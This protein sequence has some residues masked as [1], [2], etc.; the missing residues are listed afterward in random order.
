[1]IDAT[2]KREK[3]DKE[4][5]KGYSKN[6]AKNGRLDWIKGGKMTR[7]ATTIWFNRQFDIGRSSVR[8]IVGG[9]LT[10]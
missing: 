7:Y 4:K 9:K 5:T 3:E 2:E 8:N 1:M 10:L 6:I